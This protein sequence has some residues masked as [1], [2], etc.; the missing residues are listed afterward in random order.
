MAA[1]LTVLGGLCLLQ[2]LIL[3]GIVAIGAG[4]QGSPPL[5]FSMLAL[6]SLVSVSIGL[7]T[8]RKATYTSPTH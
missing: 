7:R 2:C 3:L 5:L 1:K 4:L 6:V 8:C